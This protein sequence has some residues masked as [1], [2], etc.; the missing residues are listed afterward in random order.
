MKIQKE[1]PPYQQQAYRA[2]KKH[3]AKHIHNV[4]NYRPFTYTLEYKS[5]CEHK[6]ASSES[7]YF[8]QLQVFDDHT[9]YNYS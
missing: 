6:L 5:K 9:N 7:Q 4:V 1:N 3:Y 8:V 2:A